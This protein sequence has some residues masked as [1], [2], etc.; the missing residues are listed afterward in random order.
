MKHQN[1]ISRKSFLLKLAGITGGILLPSFLSKIFNNSFNGSNTTRLLNAA[2]PADEKLVVITGTDISKATIEKMVQK[3]L[4]QFGGIKGLIKNGMN[5]VIKPNIAWNA[6]PENAATTNPYLVETVARLCKEAGGKVT[7]FDR[8]CSSAR[9]SYKRSGIEDAAERAGVKIEFVDE[10]KFI[11]VK[12]PNALNSNTL[13]VY[14]P[15]LDA[16]FVI[17]MPIAKHHSTSELTISMKNLMGVMG[18]NRG[19]LHWNINENIVDFT[20]AVKVDLIICDCLRI[21]TNHGP[22]SGTPEDVKEIRTIIFG[23]NPVTVDAYTTTLFGKS[24]ADIKY[25]T[26]AYKEKMGEINPAKMNLSRFTV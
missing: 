10:R 16:D 4:G 11:D 6:P 15:I 17:N 8:T 13:S 23:K 3:A 5:V 9:L 21:L 18:G 14:K 24:P 26:L 20:K 12:V 7:I 1:H 25:L 22:N 19:M 2:S